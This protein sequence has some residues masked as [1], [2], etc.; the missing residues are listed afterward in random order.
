[1][2]IVCDLNTLCTLPMHSDSFCLPFILHIKNNIYISHDDL[3]M[4]D[5]ENI[6]LHNI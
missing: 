1:M 3:S 2:F 5:T 4:T 6:L